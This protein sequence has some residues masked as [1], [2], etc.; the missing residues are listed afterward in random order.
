MQGK[1]TIWLGAAVVALLVTA[2]LAPA[3]AK[4]RVHSFAG[5]CSVQ[6][7]VAFSPPATNSQ[8]LLHVVYDANGTCDG[9][10][11]GRQV[12]G[13]PIDMHNEATSD[14][15]CLRADT[16][17]PGHGAMEFADGT[18]IA[19]S[20]EFHYVGTDGVQT[21]QGERSGSAIG[22]GS[23]LTQRT[24]P[25]TTQKCAGEGVSEVPMDLSLTTQSPL[26]SDGGPSAKHG[27]RQ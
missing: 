22:H 3:S 25:D 15:S 5:S 16:V 11:G 7:T 17:E 27:G 10:L 24:P 6:G 23:F 9:T 14:G 21:F 26:V 18:V 12:S 4:Q 8:Q 13:A 1:R 2:G 19:Y 20:L